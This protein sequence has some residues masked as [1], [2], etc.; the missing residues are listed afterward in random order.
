[1]FRTHV[2]AGMTPEAFREYQ[3]ALVR[4]ESKAVLAIDARVLKDKLDETASWWRE[5]EASSGR[6]ASPPTTRER[7]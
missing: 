1:M 2:E 7:M 4:Q 5:E 6:K 3:E